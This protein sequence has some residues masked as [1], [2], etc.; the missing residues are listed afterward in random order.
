MGGTHRGH[1]ICPLAVPGLQPLHYVKVV[2]DPHH[3]AHPEGV[4]LSEREAREGLQAGVAAQGPRRSTGQAGLNLT[5][6]H[7]Q[8][9]NQSV[10]LDEGHRWQA[11][12]A[13]KPWE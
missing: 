12:P 7:A 3:I 1:V 11:V 10:W 13:P 8:K 2:D 4:V 5:L 6:A 9:H